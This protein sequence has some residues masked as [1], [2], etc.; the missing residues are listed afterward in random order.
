MI[1]IFTISCNP[2]KYVLKHYECL[3][4]SSDTIR[5]YITETI[6]DSIS[7]IEG[8]ESILTAWVECDSM[9]NVILKKYEESNT[10]GIKTIIKYS[11]NKLEI[12][13][14]TDSIAVLNKIITKLKE[15]KENK[16]IVI[17]KDKN[18]SY[19]KL[20]YLSIVFFILFISIRFILRKLI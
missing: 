1:A 3:P 11:N 15:S 4:I 18:I 9:Y 14:Y 20:F 5:E 7:Y 12:R 16:V 13:A 19:K 6:R 8:N 2:C 17:N 10:G